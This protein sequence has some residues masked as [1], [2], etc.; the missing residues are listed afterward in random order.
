VEA[1]LQ[2]FEVATVLKVSQRVKN[3]VATGQLPT[4]RIGRTVRV[5]SADLDAF[6][7]SRTSARV[8]E[9]PVVVELT[10]PIVLTPLK[11]VPGG[12]RILYIS[13]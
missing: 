12:S 2:L 3:I 5:A 4:V 1:L 10:P 8:S 9:P 7:A 6:I 13:K 11:R